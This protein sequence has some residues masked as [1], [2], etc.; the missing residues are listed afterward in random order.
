MR[1]ALSLTEALGNGAGIPR[2]WAF[3]RI[4]WRSAGVSTVAPLADNWR[5]VGATHISVNTMG[6]E[7]RS[8]QDRLSA[9]G[10][11]AAALGMERP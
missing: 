11:R 6:T 5:E 10:H 1:E 3:K 7:I 2:G 8:A 4:S 9:P